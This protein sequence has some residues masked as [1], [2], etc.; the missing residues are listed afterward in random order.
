MLEKEIR[1]LADKIY[2]LLCTSGK[3][4]LHELEKSTHSKECFWLSLGW[5]LRENKGRIYQHDNIWYFELKEMYK[6]IY[7]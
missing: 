5:L 4:N 2:T 6:E 1:T 3:I 7:Y